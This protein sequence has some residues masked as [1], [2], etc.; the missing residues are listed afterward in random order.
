M[1]KLLSDNLLF[2]K[3][4]VL[5]QILLFSEP[6]KARQHCLHSELISVIL[7]YSDH[8]L[9]LHLH[10]SVRLDESLRHVNYLFARTFTDF[11]RCLARSLIKAL[12]FRIC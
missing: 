8:L 6:S 11:Y 2:S 10:A 9:F 12:L 1:S 7:L 3:E 4:Y 5:N